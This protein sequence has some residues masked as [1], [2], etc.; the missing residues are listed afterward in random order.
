MSG[1][2]VSRFRGDLVWRLA[3]SSP[4][5]FDSNTFSDVSLHVNRQP[6]PSSK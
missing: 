4:V 6:C 3:E 2:I 5:A 1:M